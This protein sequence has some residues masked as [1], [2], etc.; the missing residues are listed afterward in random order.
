MS[1]HSDDV[2]VDRFALAMK[3]KLAE[4]RAKGRGGWD[5]PNRCTIEYLA[6][7]LVGHTTKGNEGTFEDIANFAMMLHQRGADPS[8]LLTVKKTGGVVEKDTGVFDGLS[9][10]ELVILYQ[11][12]NCPAGDSLSFL[13]ETVS[14]KVR[15]L[16]DRYK[17]D[18]FKKVKA[19]C[20]S[21]GIDPYNCTVKFTTTVL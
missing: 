2:A 4:S 6:E 14:S 10:A 17:T 16:A 20:E 11:V 13:G 9:A 5:D 7:L 21:R 18:L 3:K 15:R 1:I 19:R 12:L 8:V